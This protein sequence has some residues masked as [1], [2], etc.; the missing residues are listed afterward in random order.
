MP[1]GEGQFSYRS[2]YR[3]GSGTPR[4]TWIL[5]HAALFAATR[6]TNLYFPASWLLRGDFVGGPVAP[7][8]GHGVRDVPVRTAAR[9]GWLAHTRYWRRHP[10]DAAAPDAPLVCLREAIDLEGQSL[11]GTPSSR[12]PNPAAGGVD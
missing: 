8:F 6:W 5:H 4:T 2:N 9:R 11:G 10:E 1:E 12:A 3:T 7:L